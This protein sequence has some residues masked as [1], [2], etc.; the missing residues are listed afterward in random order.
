MAFLQHLLGWWGFHPSEYVFF[1]PSDIYTSLPC[2][3]MCFRLL[4]LC[5]LLNVKYAQ[6]FPYCLGWLQTERPW[7]WASLASLC[8]GPWARHIYPSLV[9]VQ[10]RKTCSFIT[11]RLWWH[12]KNQIKQTNKQICPSFPILPWLLMGL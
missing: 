8:C 11:E 7:V 1:S 12:I 6:A 5:I 9:L 4:F 2:R 3:N 10:P